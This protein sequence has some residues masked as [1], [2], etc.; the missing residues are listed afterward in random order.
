M[1]KFYLI[2]LVALLFSAISF[3]QP[4]T[5]TV[6]LT[7]RDVCEN[8]LE[9]HCSVTNGDIYDWD[10]S[11]VQGTLTSAT[12]VDNDAGVDVESSVGSG[13]GRVIVYAKVRYFKTGQGWSNWS[14][15]KQGTNSEV[16]DAPSAP[17]GPSEGET[18]GSSWYSTASGFADYDW[19]VTGG[20]YSKTEYGNQC[21]VTFTSTGTFRIYVK[22]K[23]YGACGFS[24]WSPYKTTI[25]D[26]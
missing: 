26:Y 1:K 10:L 5:P 17:S 19:Y 6:A 23:N 18:Y 22:V 16:P 8:T 4:S 13:Y 24:N 20:S 12:L 14:N 25:V 15:V 21:V 9:Y 2:S 3:A 11:A 7:T